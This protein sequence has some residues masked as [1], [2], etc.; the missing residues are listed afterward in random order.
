MTCCDKCMTL[1]LGRIR[2]RLLTRVP[3]Q[4]K[5]EKEKKTTTLR[6][7][8]NNRVETNFNKSCCKKLTSIFSVQSSTLNQTAPLYNQRKV[9]YSPH[10]RCM[11]TEIHHH[12]L[13]SAQSTKKCALRS[14]AERV[15]GLCINA[16]PTMTR[17]SYGCHWSFGLTVCSA[18]G[19][20][21]PFI[22][23]LLTT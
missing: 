19:Q 8:K 18:H 6:E 17:K 12:G 21:E 16:K 23:S 14:E 22:A 1:A 11:F 9:V 10:P 3:R 15:I 7:H 13:T 4:I 5:P 2:K 20:R